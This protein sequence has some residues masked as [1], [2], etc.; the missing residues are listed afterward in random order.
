MN[1]K[2]IQENQKYFNHTDCLPFYFFGITGNEESQ[3]TFLHFNM[4]SR[5]D[6]GAGR[7]H[8]SNT[9]NQQGMWSTYAVMH[10]VKAHVAKLQKFI[11]FGWRKKLAVEKHIKKKH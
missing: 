4:I 5:V 11:R 10:A 1:C 6:Q 9:S 2:S 3:S 8:K 7:N